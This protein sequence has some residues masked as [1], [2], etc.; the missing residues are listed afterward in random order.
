LSF[1]AELKKLTDIVWPEIRALASRE[2]AKCCESG[3][4]VVVLDAAVLVEAGWT[5][6]CNEV[7]VSIIPESE[8]QKLGQDVFGATQ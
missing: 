1:Q 3:K 6:L 4:D 7:W 8:V 2:I 5:D